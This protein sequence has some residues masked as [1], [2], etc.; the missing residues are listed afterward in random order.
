LI[1]ESGLMMGPLLRRTWAPQGQ[2]PTVTQQGAHRQKVSVAAALWLSPRRDRL[3]LYYHTLAGGYFDNWYVTA[4]IEAMLKDLG[5]RFVVIWDGGTMHKGEPIEALA[6]HFADRLVLERLPPFAPMLNPVEW[7]WSWLKWER[8]SNF[9]PHD[10]HELDRR[11]GAE[12][13]S[14]RDDQGFL[15]NLFHA[16]ELPLPRALLS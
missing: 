1:D 15:R 8:L 5:G 16:S 10:V 7:L 9:A 12:L 2:T 3:G 11:V 13:A 14:K 4:F 6:S